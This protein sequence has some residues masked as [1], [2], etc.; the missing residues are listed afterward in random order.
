[1]YPL[2]LTT[3]H[4]HALR[5]WITPRPMPLCRNTPRRHRMATARTP[6]FTTA[7]GV[8]H[9]IHR[10]TSIMRPPTK[11]ALTPCFTKA[12]KLVL[13]VAY[14]SNRRAAPNVHFPH[15]TRRHAN[16][17]V[18]TFF[19]QKTSASS[20]RSHQLSS[21]TRS[22]FKVVDLCPHG[23][24]RQRQMIASRNGRLRPRLNRLPNTQTLWS[25]NVALFTI[26]VMQQGN[27]RGPIRIVLNGGN[28]RLHTDLI[29]PKVNATPSAFVAPAT[30]T[31]SDSSFIVAP[32]NGAFALCQRLAGFR[33][34][35][36]LKAA[37]AR[38]SP[39]RT[40][41]FVRNG[42]HDELSGPPE[43]CVGGR[44]SRDSDVKSMPSFSTSAESFNVTKALFVFACRPE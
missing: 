6:A 32:A 33:P 36:F 22:E 42:A 34:R 29:P 1:M 4:D 9:R 19:P 40:R 38:A 16:R 39:S 12:P 25:K 13:R 43:V 44:F 7:Q 28:L 27:V 30:K 15:L 2:L 11:P 5:S 24:R 31:N 37:N 21:F 26:N 14:F 18:R 20:R 17:C 10:D 3:S 35:N 41:W 8:I 23:N